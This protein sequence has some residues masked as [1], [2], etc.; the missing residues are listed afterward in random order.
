M[1]HQHCTCGSGFASENLQL[2]KE[3]DVGVESRKPLGEQG[4]LE[5]EL[6]LSDTEIPKNI[7]Q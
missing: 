3:F 6:L 4:L 5:R 1:R 7:L 2:N